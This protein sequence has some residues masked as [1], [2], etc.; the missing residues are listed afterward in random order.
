[1]F[2]GCQITLAGGD[3]EHVPQRIDRRVLD[4]AILPMPMDKEIYRVQ[5]ILQSPVVRLRDDDLLVSQ[6]HAVLSDH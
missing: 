6:G 4:C 5:Q 3:L 1:M 2:S